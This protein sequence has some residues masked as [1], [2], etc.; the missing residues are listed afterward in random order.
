MSKR[1][2]M[3]LLIGLVLVVGGCKNKTE[4]PPAENQWNIVFVVVDTMRQDHL[5]CYGYKRPTTP[6]IDRLARQSVVFEN[7]YS[8]SPWTMPSVASM[9]TSLVPRDHGIANWKQPMAP[10]H[11]T[12]AEHLQANGYYTSA[13]VSHF[14]FKPKYHF[15]QGFDRFDYS[16]LDK[17]PP[18]KIHTAK[19]VSD[20]AVKELSGSIKEPFFMWL[21]Y[22]D[23]HNAYLPHKEFD[24]GKKSKDLYDGEIAYTDHHFGR[25]LKKLRQSGLDERTILVVITD[26]GEE[27]RDH[28]GIQHSRTLYDELLRIAL[29]VRVP[30]LKPGRVPTVV[31]EMDVAPTLLNLLRLPVPER[32]KGEPFLVQDGTLTA[33]GD[34]V[35]FAETYRFAD[36]Q[37]LRF[38]RWKLIH[39]REKQ[40]FQLFDLQTDPRE[41]KNLFSKRTEMA[42]KLQKTLAEHYQVARAQVEEQELTDDLKK[43]LKSLGYI[44]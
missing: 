28:G 21:H 19:E 10:R 29:I 4:A 17:G 43:Q 30:G 9:F 22:F 5:G 3:G 39:D 38:G 14:I 20:L 26:H 18:K 16:V 7:A 11:L 13:Y 41:K 23:P 2:L 15:D 44:Q 31:S 12:L 36:K 6:N 32:F 34:R 42:A 40:L 27:F 1:V 37:G 25:V 35:I 24:F 8:H 33:E